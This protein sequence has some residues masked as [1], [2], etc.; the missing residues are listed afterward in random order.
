MH[1]RRFNFANPTLRSAT[2]F[3]V[4]VGICASALPIPLGR[5]V[6]QVKDL[7]Q[8]FPCQHCACGCKNAEECWT[9]CC[10]FTPTQRAAWAKENG[11][12]PPA[13]AV[14]SDGAELADSGQSAHG[15]SAK[16]CCSKKL[17]MKAP[18]R[19]MEPTQTPKKSTCPHCDARSGCKHQDCKSVEKCTMEECLEESFASNQCSEKPCSDDADLSAEDAEPTETVLVLSIMAY[20]CSGQATV[21]SLLPWAIIETQPHMSRCWELVGRRTPDEAFS[22]IRVFLFPDVP[23]PR[24]V[25]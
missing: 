4:L 13:Y 11:V 20:K 1:N 24:A 14:L 18:L 21:F 10:C 25:G 12:T 2:A 19:S 3:L 23:P 9:H 6:R 5:I 16:S 15:N 22:P 7:S 17:T 8:P